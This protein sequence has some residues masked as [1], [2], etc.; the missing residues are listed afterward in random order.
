MD[1][2][3][4][5]F[6]SLTLIVTLFVAIYTVHGRVKNENKEKHKPYLILKSLQILK[7]LD[8]YKY[9]ITLK[10]QDVGEEIDIPFNIMLENIGY[11]V[12]S[13]IRF[14]DLLTGECIKGTQLLDR[15][16]NQQLFTTLDVAS[17][18]IIQIQMLLINYLN[19]NGISHNRIL[20]IYQDLNENIYDFIIHI[21][22]K[23]KKNYDFYA[24]QRTS[25]S[26]H[27]SIEEYKKEYNMILKDYKGESSIFH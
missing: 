2:I 27:K 14:Y 18:D 4:I 26:Y 25:K 21:N 15:D 8:Q 19:K 23:S 5:I 6:S 11:G 16:I 20:C 13:N 17:S 9:Y 22:I 10:K 1:R 24:Y 3:T 7:K 12:A